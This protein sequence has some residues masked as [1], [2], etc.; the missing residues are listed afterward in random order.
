[1]AQFKGQLATVQKNQEEASKA[2][3]LVL[4]KGL[5]L[6]ELLIDIFVCIDWLIGRKEY[7]SLGLING[8]IVDFLEVSGHALGVGI[9]PDFEVR[10]VPLLKGFLPDAFKLIEVDQLLG[11]LQSFPLV[12]LSLAAVH[13]VVGY[14]DLASSHAVP[15]TQVLLLVAS[16]EHDLLL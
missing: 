14:L 4:A 3:L 16:L 15:Q 8:V 1:L 13:L 10:N 6:P 7:Q 12:I 2:T 9:L 5:D 11:L